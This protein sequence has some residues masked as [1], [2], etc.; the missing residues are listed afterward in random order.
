MEPN[1]L[2]QAVAGRHLQAYAESTRPFGATS[3]VLA[4]P[5][6]AAKGMDQNA[7]PVGLSAAFLE[8]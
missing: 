7:S 6:R 1:R 8:R 5:G 2:G 3:V 4:I